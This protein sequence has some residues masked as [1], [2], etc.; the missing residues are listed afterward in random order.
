MEARGEEDDLLGEDRKL[1][2]LRLA[3]LPPDPDDVAAADEAV[4]GGEGVV[5]A[6]VGGEV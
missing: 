4:D 2:L 6:R 3:R 5:G 1:P